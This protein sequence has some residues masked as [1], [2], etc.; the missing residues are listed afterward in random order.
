[1]S[2]SL[3][4]GD[5]FVLLG[6][7]VSELEAFAVDS[8]QAAFRGRQIYDWLYAKGVKNVES[9]TVLPK[10][11]RKQLEEIDVQ[12]GRLQEVNRVISLDETIKLLLHQ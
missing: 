5:K 6:L 12:G 7:S 10:A 8:G 1:M 3:S 11:W 9:I 2:A 4:R